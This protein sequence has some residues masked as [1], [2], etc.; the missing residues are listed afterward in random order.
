MFSRIFSRSQ[1]LSVD[2]ETFRNFHSTVWLGARCKDNCL[3]NFDWNILQSKFFKKYEFQI[4]NWFQKHLENERCGNFCPNW[5]S[6]ELST[7]S[8]RQFH[9]C[10]SYAGTKKWFLCDAKMSCLEKPGKHLKLGT[11]VPFFSWQVRDRLARAQKQL[12]RC[13]HPWHNLTW[14]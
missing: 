2:F 13:A 10:E 12:A 7:L 11:I 9:I 14:R 5:R 1:N 4:N 3:K 8:H 6:W